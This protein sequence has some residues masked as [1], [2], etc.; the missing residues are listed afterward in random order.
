[1]TYRRPTPR[2]GGAQGLE[3]QTGQTYVH[4]SPHDGT[5]LL[6]WVLGLPSKQGQRQASL[7]VLVPV[8][9]RS[10]AG[11]DLRVR[12][13]GNGHPCALA[14]H[15]SPH[16]PTRGLLLSHRAG[17]L[18]R[19]LALIP[20]PNPTPGQTSWV[21]HRKAARDRVE[22]TPRG[23]RRSTSPTWGPPAPGGRPRTLFRGERSPRDRG[24]PSRVGPQDQLTF[25]GDSG[26]RAG[27]RA[28]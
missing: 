3:K 22:G 21:S 13:D 17:E 16:P 5:P 7:D 23:R 6:T 18:T 15:G 28:S 24:A 4:I 2:Q 10:D 12:G 20:H 14:L 26:G 27:K 1:M 19:M 11:K 8:D 25:A 9:G